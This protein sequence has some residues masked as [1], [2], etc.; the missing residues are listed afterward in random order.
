MDEATRKHP[1]G[2]D[3]GLPLGRWPDSTRPMGLGL[4]VPISEESAFGGTPRFA[5]MLEIA[6]TAEAVGF[7]AV[8]FADHFLLY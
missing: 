7:D 4:M 2:A 8:W 1:T 3:G 6:R 5:D